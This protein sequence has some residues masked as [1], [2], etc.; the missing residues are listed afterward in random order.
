M[1]KREKKIT[2]V[3]INHAR[4]LRL[5]EATIPRQFLVSASKP[6]PDKFFWFVLVRSRAFFPW[7]INTQSG[8]PKIQLHTQNGR[9]K[10]L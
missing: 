3:L 10:K 8:L 6:N 9:Q 2:T 5:I 7:K 1:H 4:N